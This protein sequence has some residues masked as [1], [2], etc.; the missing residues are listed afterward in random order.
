VTNFAFKLRMA[1]QRAE[2]ILREE[3]LN[4]VP[5]DILKLAQSRDIA[6]QAKPDTMAGV[7]GMLLRH[8]DTF[9]ILYAIHIRSEGFQRFSIAHELGHY[10]L[11]GHID[12]I[13]PKD[14]THESRAGFVLA[15]PYEMEADHFAAGLLMPAD[16]F[17]KELRR[18]DDGLD[19]VETLAGLFKSS[20]TATAIRYGELTDAAVA[21]IMSTGQTVDYCFLSDGM[22]SLKGLTWIRKGSAIPRGTETSRYNAETARVAKASRS[23]CEIDVMDWLGGERS[24]RPIEEVVG[25]GNYGKTLTI[26][27]CPALDADDA[28]N[29]DD[30]D[31]IERWT[32]RFR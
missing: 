25:L 24:V 17:R 14:G 26:V 2:Q 30:D 5:V 8:G 32:P 16:I 28:D 6:V 4:T 20:L 29:D 11:D 9:G 10:F 31:L 13:L 3:G 15:D 7:S 18:L 12:Q 1:K 19:A 23:S 21:V 27:T 22:K